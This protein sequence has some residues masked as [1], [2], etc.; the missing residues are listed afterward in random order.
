M[1]K[2]QTR[3]YSSSSLSSSK[4]AA[5]YICFV[6][7]GLVDRLDR[8]PGM[9]FDASTS[10]PDKSSMTSEFSESESTVFFFFCFFFG[11]SSSSSVLSASSCSR[12]SPRRSKVSLKVVGFSIIAFGYKNAQ[13]ERERERERERPPSHHHHHHQNDVCAPR[14]KTTRTKRRTN[15]RG[16]SAT[17]RTSSSFST[18]FGRSPSDSELS[19]SNTTPIWNFEGHFQKK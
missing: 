12:R 15:Q 13:M 9:M 2:L 4:F 1:E 16:V 8:P 5:A 10:S 19:L 3:V 11:R 14:R 6:N 17:L 18:F 7:T